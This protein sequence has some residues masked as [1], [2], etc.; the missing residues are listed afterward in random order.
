MSYFQH[1]CKFKLLGSRKDSLSLNG[2]GLGGGE[3][4]FFTNASSLKKIKKIDSLFG[5]LFCRR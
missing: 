2:K 4:R 1:I 3:I 5:V